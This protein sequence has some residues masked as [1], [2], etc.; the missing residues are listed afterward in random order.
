MSKEI[1]NIQQDTNEM[2]ETNIRDR[3]KQPE[4]IKKLW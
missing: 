2:A 1:K 3:A 4:N